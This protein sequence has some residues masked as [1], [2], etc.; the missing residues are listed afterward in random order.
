[1]ARAQAGH[2]AIAGIDK[3]D[4]IYQAG[5]R[6]AEFAQARVMLADQTVERARRG[7]QVIQQV[8]ARWV[9]R[10]SGPSLLLIRLRGRP[11]GRGLGD[12]LRRHR[13][14]DCAGVARWKR[15]IERPR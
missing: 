13:R 7:A 15:H 1:M 5:C 9:I 12:R 3:V 6:A 11:A 4:V 10:R 2:A 14:L 8:E